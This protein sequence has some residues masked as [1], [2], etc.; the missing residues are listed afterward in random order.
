MK[1]S[2]GLILIA[3]LSVCLQG[4]ATVEGTAR[5]V[6]KDADTAWGYVNKEDGWIKQTDNWMKEHLW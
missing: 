4:C 1:L 5:G 6:K 2:G 3:L